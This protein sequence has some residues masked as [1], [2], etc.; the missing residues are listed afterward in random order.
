MA[1]QH[2]CAKHMPKGYKKAGGILHLS[3]LSELPPFIYTS[4]SQ[5]DYLTCNTNSPA[6]T[7]NALQFF[8]LSFPLNLS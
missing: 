2:V 3:K 4:P 5:S 7:T 1:L 6:S 8:S